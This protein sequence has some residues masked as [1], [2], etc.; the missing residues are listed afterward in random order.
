MLYN[1]RNP[2]F[3]ADFLPFRVGSSAVGDADFIYPAAH[4]CN[5]CGYFGLETK[6][7]FFYTNR[8]YDLASEY[9]IHVSISVRLM[10]VNMFEK[11]VSSLLPTE[12]Q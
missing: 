7:I 6:S 8:L 1:A 11:V 12:C 9:S 2:S 3:P 4:F 10:F 5:L